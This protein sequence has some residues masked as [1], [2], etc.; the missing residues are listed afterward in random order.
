MTKLH[1]QLLK[2]EI[3]NNLQVSV[4]VNAKFILLIKQ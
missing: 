4:L 2:V 1:I 3:N